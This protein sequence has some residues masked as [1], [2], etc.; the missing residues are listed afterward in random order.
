M[1]AL[2]V[3]STCAKRDDSI[4]RGDENPT[5]LTRVLDVGSEEGPQ[6]V[7]LVEMHGRSAKYALL[8]TA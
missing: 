7:R 4:C 1:P 8:V 3:G 5:L 6:A 2:N